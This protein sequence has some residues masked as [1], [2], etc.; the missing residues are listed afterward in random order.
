[1]HSRSLSIESEILLTLLHVCCDHELHFPP[2]CGCSSTFFDS[3]LFYECV[4]KGRALMI[5]WPDVSMSIILIISNLIP[6]NKRRIASNPVFFKLEI[7][8][9]VFVIISAFSQTPVK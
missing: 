2:G 8:V 4:I 9:Q 1:V 3:D 6:S 7:R 5:G